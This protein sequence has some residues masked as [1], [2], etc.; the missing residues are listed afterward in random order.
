LDPEFALAYMRLADLYAL[1]GDQRRYNQIAIKVDQMQSRLPRY[2]QLYLEVLKSDRSRDLELQVQTRQALVAEFPRESTV[3]A[4]LADALARTGRRE[5]S[6]EVIRQGFAMDPKNEDLLNAQSYLLAR[7]S[8]FNTALTANDRYATVRPSDANPHDSRGDILYQ[9]GQDDEAIAAYRK[10]IEI[11][12][13]FSDYGDYLKLAIVYADQKKRDMSEAAFQQFAQHSDALERL[14]LPGFEAQLQQMR[15]DFEGALGSYRRAVLQLGRAGQNEVAATFL[16]E[17]ASLSVMVGQSSAAL[18]FVQQQKLEGEELQPVAFLQIMTGNTSAAE[19]SLQRF[20]SSHPWV[21][22]HAVELQKAQYEM[23]A[24][25]ERNDG[26]SAVNRATGLPDFQFPELLFLKARA[27]LLTND[28]A[29]ADAEFRRALL[30]ERD[31]SNFFVLTLRFPAFQVLSGFYLGQ[32]YERTGKRDQALSEYQEFLS[33]FD[34]S[35]TRLAQL[36]EAR[37]ALKRLMQ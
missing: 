12:P 4:D 1:Q 2:E 18:S 19:R 36:A 17:F 10:A 3:R 33:H 11:K 26:Q 8:D 15:G 29:S 35:H 13:D 20:A 9:A 22:P 5:E 16:Q 6:L 32:L 34:N 37:T 28:Y 7:W 23:A 27:H 24:A 31:L 14:Y 25:V 21:T 30:L